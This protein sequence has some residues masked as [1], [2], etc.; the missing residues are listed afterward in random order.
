MPTI[1]WDE[2]KP[3]GGDAIAQGD[4]EIRSTKTALRTA[5]DSEHVFP[6]AGGDA[7]THRLGSARAAFGTQS[8]VSSAGIDGRLMVTSDTSRL[9]HVGSEGTMLLG[10]QNVLSMGSSP[11]GGQR[12]YWAIEMQEVLVSFNL[13]ESGNVTFPNSGFSGKPFV[14]VVPKTNDITSTSGMF[15]VN[16]NARVTSSQV[17]FFS[18]EFD[19]GGVSE[20][21]TDSSLTLL[22][23]SIGTR[24]L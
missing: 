19:Q 10:G 15:L 12:F 2:A 13:G 5:L 23:L 7:G 14:L 22:I 21:A 3:A 16:T 11:V 9:F 6:S 18:V 4:D 17:S 1:K 24:T 8:L 20:G